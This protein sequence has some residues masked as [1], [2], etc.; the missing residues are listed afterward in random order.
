ME[1]NLFPSDMIRGLRQSK[2]CLKNYRDPSNSHHVYLRRGKLGEGNMH[3]KTTIERDADSFSCN[4][5]NG[6]T[7]A[8][9]STAVETPT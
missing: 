7:Q 2:F 1:S 6:K 8:Q 4:H 5:R 3:R 9:L